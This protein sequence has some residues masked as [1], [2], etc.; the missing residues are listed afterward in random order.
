VIKASF[1]PLVDAGTRVLILGSLPGE[2]SLAKGEYYA[3]PQ[4]HLWR[5]VGAVIGADIDSRHTA[6]ADRLAALTSAHV[7]LWDVVKTASRVGSLDTQIRD[8][9]PNALPDLAKTLPQLRA[10]GFNGGT[11]WKIGSTQFPADTPLALV[12]LPSSSAAY[13]IGFERKLTEWIK[14][15]AYL[16]HDDFC[17]NRQKSESCSQT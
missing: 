12:A 5:L 4:N 16:E 8:H 11:S 17:R 13:T 14:L 9:A 15:R 2:I 3:N 6:Y 7:G 1:P 10:I